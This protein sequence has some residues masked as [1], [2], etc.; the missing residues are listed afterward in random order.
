RLE[1][2]EHALGDAIAY[3]RDVERLVDDTREPRELFRLAF[4]PRRLRVEP[5]VLDRDGGLARVELDRLA[6]VGRRRRAWGKRD[7]EHAEHLVAG[8]DRD[9]VVDRKLAEER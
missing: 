4:A 3:V 8:L 6:L 5:R 1:E 2:R 7:A 9:A